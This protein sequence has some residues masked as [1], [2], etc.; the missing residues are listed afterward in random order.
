MI[1]YNPQLPWIADA[2]GNIVEFTERWL[3]GSGLTENDAKGAGWLEATHPGDIKRV[4]AEI[5]RA[6][7]SGS[8]FDV[9]VTLEV[10]S[11]EVLPYVFCHE[12]SICL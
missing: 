11:N 9:R 7:E 1:E 4:H 5:A 3:D 6:Q 8:N 2:E 12:L 10:F